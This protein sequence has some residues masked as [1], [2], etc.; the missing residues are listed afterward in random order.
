MSILF[1]ANFTSFSNFNKTP[2]PKGSNE[3]L[4]GANFKGNFISGDGVTLKFL[5][6]YA[7]P[8]L[9]LRSP[10]LVKVETFLDYKDAYYGSTK[11]FMN[12]ILLT[13]FQCNS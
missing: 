2:P 9:T 6:T 5:M 11:N 4:S 1:Y 3:T 8:S 12:I 7:I 10:N 13:S